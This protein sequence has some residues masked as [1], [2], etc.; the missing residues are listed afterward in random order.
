[1]RDALF[2]DFTELVFSYDITHIA[3]EVVNKEDEKKYVTEISL[4]V[5]QDQRD[6]W[7]ES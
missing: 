2:D 6:Q 7:L 3:E 1:M 5:S 4:L